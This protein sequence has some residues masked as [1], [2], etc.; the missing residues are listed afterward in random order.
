MAGEVVEILPKSADA[1]RC[2]PRN[3]ALPFSGHACITIDTDTSGL[4]AVDLL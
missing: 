1:L 3:R 2:V 4:L